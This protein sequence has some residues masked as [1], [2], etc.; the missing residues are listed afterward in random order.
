M[1][2]EPSSLRKHIEEA[3]K[4]RALRERRLTRK[5]R[6]VIFSGILFSLL[7]A[8][9]VY[10]AHH[11]HFQITEVTVSGNEVTESDR[12]VTLADQSLE[13]T[14][15][16][17]V[18]RRNAFFYPKKKIIKSITEAFPRLDGIAVYRTSL[19]ALAV[20][21]SEQKG[22]A[23][24]CGGDAA[25]VTNDSCYFTD[26]SG[27][28]IDAAPYYS[29]N[30]YPR[31]FGGTIHPDTVPLG[32]TFTTEDQFAKLIALR[33]R[34]MALGFPV[35]SIILGEGDEDSLVLDL[36]GASVAPVRFLK[37]D[38]YQSIADNLAAALGKKEL[39]DELAKN[40]KNLE[41][42][43]LRFTNKV[44]YKFSNE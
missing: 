3:P 10:A 20:V 36:G 7:L 31:F 5:K 12:I 44:Y 27:K 1:K 4:L 42:F 38:E 39:S 23:L 11:P 43:D 34:V 18:P 14:Y 28:I 2:R 9:F 22:N 8:G 15:A 17:L 35:K 26:G 25:A 16:Y 33:E 37:S 24:W 6:I 41:Y 13:G 40:K 19:Y 29:G 21:V 32:K 30:V